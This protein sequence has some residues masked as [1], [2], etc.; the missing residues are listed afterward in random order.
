MPKL[1]KYMDNNFVL[2]KIIL[3]KYFI[4]GNS[5]CKLIDGDIQ[6]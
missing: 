1:I 2:C 6:C 5:K 4:L 3:P